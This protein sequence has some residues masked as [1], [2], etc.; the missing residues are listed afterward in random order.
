M[1]GRSLLAYFRDASREPYPADEPVS[2]EIF[3][4]GVVFMGQWKAVRLRAPWDDSI[5]RLYDLSTD[6][7]E[8]HDLGSEQPD[9]LARLIRAYEEYAATH[10]V[11]D[12]PDDAT[13][14]AYRPGHLGD[15]VPSN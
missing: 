11:L 13:A 9:L 4:H 15:L 5:W 6:P 3:G 14:Y 12:L 7:G 1:R 2:F 10:R 8:Q